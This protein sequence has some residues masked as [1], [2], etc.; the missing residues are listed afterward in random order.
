MNKRPSIPQLKKKADKLYS[1]KLRKEAAN[2]EGMCKCYTCSSIKHW[3]ELQCGHFVTRTI[4]ALRYEPKNT[5]PQC[6]SCNLFKQGC[7]DIFA[8][9]LTKEY[10]AGIL[11]EFQEARKIQ[12]TNNEV[13]AL[14]EKVVEECTIDERIEK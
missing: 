13:R 8:Y 2:K 6:V 3:K 14:L 5:R 7:P 1:L 10:G 4:T 12:L 11:K 9:N